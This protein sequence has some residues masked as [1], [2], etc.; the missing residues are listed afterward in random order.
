MLSNFVIGDIDKEYDINPDI[1]DSGTFGYVNEAFR[2]SDGLRV[3]IKTMIDDEL[4]LD[5]SVSLVRELHLLASVKHPKCLKLVGFTLDP[6][7]KIITPFMAHGSLYSLIKKMYMGMPDPG[8]TPTKKMCAI[9]GICSAMKYLHNK[10]IIHRDFKPANIFVDDNFDIC[11]ADFGLSRKV[12]ENLYL[13]RTKLG[14]P[15]YMAPELF[16]KDKSY[17]NKIDVYSFGVSYL[18]F[19][20]RLTTL[21]DNRRKIKD[22][23]DL[24]L[25]VSNGARFVK[26]NNANESQYDVYMRCCQHNPSLRPSFRELCE[27]FENNK[28]LWFD[29]VDED[30]YKKY[31]QNCKDI[32]ESLHV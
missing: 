5:T 15:L 8:F 14:S 2:R 12:E 13:T 16:N 28:D 25:R 24:Y 3:A 32:D 19:F 1:L 21:D 10:A 22:E 4:D 23:D 17:T 29:G 9:Y 30:E 27:A 6:G 20:G 31:I 26:P 7:P 18:Q 11:I